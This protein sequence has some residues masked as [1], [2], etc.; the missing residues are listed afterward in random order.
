MIFDTIER[1][2]QYVDDT[3][4]TDTNE[5]VLI[6]SI[7]T[8]IKLKEKGINK[9]DI[10]STCTHNHKNSCVPL[11]ASCFIGAIPANFDPDLSHLD[12]IHLLKLVQ[13]K[14]LFVSTQSL[15]LMEKCL[16]EANVATELVVFGT[17]KKYSQFSEYLEPRDQ[18]TNF[19]V[20][21]IYDDRE[22]AVILFSSGTTGLPKGIC[23]SHYSLV[24]QAREGDYFLTKISDERDIHLVYTTFY[25]I[26]ALLTFIATVHDGGARVVCAKFDPFNCWKMIEKYK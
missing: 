11:A 13:P 12:T 14:I 21:P 24:T 23:L 1:L 19:R 18:E 26:T 7:R 16:I 6:R 4:E 22:T 8:A 3:D 20:T 15:P 5:Q 25:W 17:S 10:I 9:G 2:D